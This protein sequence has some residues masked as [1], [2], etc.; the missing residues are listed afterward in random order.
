MEDSDLSKTGGYVGGIV[1]LRYWHVLVMLSI[2]LLGLGVAYG[3]ITQN[4]ED[5][6]RRMGMIEQNKVVSREEFDN[7]RS[8]FRSTLDRIEHG[9]YE[10]N[11]IDKIR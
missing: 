4:Q 7:W 5:M 3:K 9:I 8:E 10:R 1:I 2:Q 6:A 11:Q